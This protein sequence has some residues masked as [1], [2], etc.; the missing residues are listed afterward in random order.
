MVIT[1]HVCRGNFRST[2]ISSGGYEPIA[3]RMLG[4]VQLRRLFPGIRQRPRRR[5]RAAALPAEG[6]EDRRGRRHHLEERH[7]GEQ[8]HGQAPHRRGGEVR[9][10]RAALRSARNAASPRPRRA[11]SSPRSSNGRRCARWS[12]SPTRCGGST[13]MSAMQRTKPPF[14]ADH[15]GSLLRPAALKEARAKRETGEI[16]G[17]AAQGGRGPRDRA[18]SSRS[19]RRSG[20]SRSPTANSAARSGTTISSA[21]STASRPISASAR[22]SSRAPQPKP[23]MLRVTGKLGTFS[24]H[25]M[26]EHFRS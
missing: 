25:P 19:R 16:D 26:L 8:G 1:T 9:A 24:G 13:W 21:S 11:T 15:V 7:A 3:E 23:M 14:R 5:L 12:R 6:Q 18:A 22:S 20:S 2:W 4:A 10:A 17:G